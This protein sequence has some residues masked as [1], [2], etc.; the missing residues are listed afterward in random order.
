MLRFDSHIHSHH[1]HDS[2]QS[3]EDI[4][5]AAK[6]A[7]LSGVTITDHA[8]SWYLKKDRVFEHIPASVTEAILADGFYEGELRFFAGIELGDPLN[9]PEQTRR[10]LKLAEYDVVLASVHCVRFAD[11]DDA[12]SRVAFEPSMPDSVIHAFLDAYFEEVLET[13]STQDYDVLAHLT[14]PLRYINGLYHRGI[15]IDPQGACIGKILQA[16]IDREKAVEVNTAGI[17]NPEI[18]ILP[19]R[20]ILERYYAMGGRRITLG[21]DAH[22]PERVG[23]GFDEA[24]GLLKEIGF[25]GYCHYEKRRPVW[26]AF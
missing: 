16:V 17:G 11:W 9:D 7:G 25:A 2:R 12:Y 14:C 19:E 3:M 26:D 21:S 6:A 1:S 13:A 5:R 8:D 24:V 4:F 10:L 23:N 22:V 15:A 18:S 20:A